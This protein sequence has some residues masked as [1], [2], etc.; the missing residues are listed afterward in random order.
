M[1]VNDRNNSVATKFKIVMA[2]NIPTTNFTVLVNCAIQNYFS[3]QLSPK[4]QKESRH[5]S[6]VSEVGPDATLMHSTRPNLK[7]NISVWSSLCQ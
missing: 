6:Q 7:Q 5:Y 4:A 2:V 1:Q 3:C